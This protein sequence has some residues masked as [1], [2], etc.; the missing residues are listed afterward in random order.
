[1]LTKKIFLQYNALSP[2]LYATNTTESCLSLLIT[3]PKSKYYGIEILRVLMAVFV[4]TLHLFNWICPPNSDVIGFIVKKIGESAVPVFWCLSGFIFYAVYSDNIHNRR[5]GVRAFFIARFSRLYPLAF[6]TLLITLALNELYIKINHRS[7]IWHRG[8]VYHFVLNMFM[9]SHWGFQ[10]F[11]AF[12]GPIW[13]VSAEVLIYIIFFAVIRFFGKSY[14]IAMVMI[15]V[16]KISSHFEPNLTNFYSLSSCGQFFFTGAIAYGIYAHVIRKMLTRAGAITTLTFTTSVIVYM[17]FPDRISFQLLPPLTVLTIQLLLRNVPNYV[18]RHIENLGS[19]TYASYLLH[20]PTLLT[21]VLMMDH[22]HVPRKALTSWPGILSFL[23][24]TLLI[25]RIVF[26][27]F[28]RPLQTKIR[29][30][31]E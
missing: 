21:T 30:L 4:I 10:K 7:F 29:K 16:A 2:Q 12:N 17:Y 3:T 20:Y 8:D 28:E 6:S 26:V 31:T 14:V 5:T 15:C 1:V 13:S 18:S 24:V 11:T 19:V 27:T 23:G 25:S 22:L 9:A